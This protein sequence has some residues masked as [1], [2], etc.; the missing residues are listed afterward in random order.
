MYTCVHVYMHM[1]IILVHIALR[2]PFAVNATVEDLIG[3]TFWK[4]IEECEDEPVELVRI[5]YTSVCT[6]HVHV[7]VCIQ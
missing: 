7:R 5:S 2:R 4:Y 6:V 3:L 1:Y